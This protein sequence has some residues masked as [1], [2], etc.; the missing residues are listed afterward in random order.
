MTV[1]DIGFLLVST[2]PRSNRQMSHA[3][4][5]LSILVVDW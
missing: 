5:P 1:F 4:R 3:A 2:P